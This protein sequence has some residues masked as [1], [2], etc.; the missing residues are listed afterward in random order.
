VRKLCGSG[1]LPATPE[2]M[3][4]AGYRVAALPAEVI[5][6][7]CSQRGAR[8]HIVPDAAGNDY[9]SNG[10]L[11]LFDGHRLADTWAR[12]ARLLDEHETFRR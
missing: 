1:E 10:H 5:L 8:I 2:A 3:F 9:E 11:Q 6:E 4:R 7:A 12:H